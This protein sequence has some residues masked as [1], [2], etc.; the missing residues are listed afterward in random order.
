MK[1]FSDT[2]LYAKC[3]AFKH[4]HKHLLR[5]LKPFTSGH[6]QL[7]PLFHSLRMFLTFLDSSTYLLGGVLFIV[8]SAVM[9]LSAQS[10]SVLHQEDSGTKLGP[11]LKFKTHPPPQKKRDRGQTSNFS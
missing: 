5:S 11:L 9:S 4:T 3:G 8:T 7:E 10:I 1:T 6:D 2:S